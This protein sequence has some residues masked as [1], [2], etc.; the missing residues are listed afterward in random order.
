MTV[1]EDGV[2]SNGKM[3]DSTKKVTVNHRCYLNVIFSDETR[4]D[5]T[6]KRNWLGKYDLTDGLKNNQELHTDIST[7]YN[8]KGC[9]V[10]S[11]NVFPSLKL[12]HNSNAGVFDQTTWQEI[13]QT[14]K[15][16]C[17]EYVRCFS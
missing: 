7:E 4:P 12:G 3:D 2:Y 8:D 10:Y 1:A 6:S 11:G 9:L 13:M 5:L 17:N 16:M 15:M 14:L